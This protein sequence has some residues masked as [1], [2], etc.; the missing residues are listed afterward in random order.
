[1]LSKAG[2]QVPVTPLLEVVGSGDKVAPEHIGPTAV[3]VGV[4]LELTTIVIVAVLAHCPA[5]GV[6]VYVVVVVLSKA[7]AQAP[8]IP[9]LEVVGSADKVAPEHI[10]AT[11][12]N[13]GVI[14]GL[15]VIVNVVVVAHCPAVGVKVY[16]VV[17]VLSTAGAQV[18]VM[19][20]LVVVGSG[21][22]VAPEQIG[23][24]AVNVGV[25]LGLTVIV[26]VVVVAHCPAVGV[27]VYVVVWVLSTAGAHVP[28]MP[29][30]EVVGNGAI[31][32][33]EQI[34]PTAVNVGVM[35]ELTTIVSVVVDAHCPAVG[36]K[37]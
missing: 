34:G 33:P 7:G 25:T 6:K 3:N 37:V 4:M 21:V 32:A 18:P 1:V 31:V 30:L 15:T 10:G 23:A 29:L 14:L 13:V 28:V 9:L 22:N 8:V 17:W 27:K 19:P 24:T 36:V 35:L 26:N 12:V 11:A 20:L 16:V 5:S 2:D